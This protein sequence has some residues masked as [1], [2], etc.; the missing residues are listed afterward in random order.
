[1]G[2][3]GSPALKLN[4]LTQILQDGHLVDDASLVE[5]ASAIVAARL[6]DNS[7]VR[8]HIKQT[9]SGLGSSSIWSLYAQIWL[10]SK[11]SS[12]DELMAIIDT[13]AS[14]WG[15]NEH[16]TRLVAGMFS[17]FVGSPLQSKFEAILRK[18]GGF[19]TS[20]VTQL[21][22][23]LANTVAG[24]TA[25]RKFIVAHNTSLPNRISHASF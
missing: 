24:F 20:S 19:A 2:L 22:R 8:G 12:N 1:M 18:A 10:A 7:W 15:S 23:E 17:R 11:Y 13:K 5:I 16:L 3:T 25:I 14:M 6:P 21:H 9:L 4:L